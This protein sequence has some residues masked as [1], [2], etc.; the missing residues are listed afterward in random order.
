MNVDPSKS[1][2]ASLMERPNT[3][4]RARMPRPSELSAAQYMPQ[5]RTV[6]NGFTAREVE[7][8]TGL[9]V[10]MVDYLSREGYL[11]PT[12]GLERVRGRVR[13]YS[14]RDLMVARIVQR[15]RERGIELRRLKQ[16]IQR[17]SEDR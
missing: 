8:I 4:S 2:N 3:T 17:L 16:S 12:Y 1:A 10:P 5:P 14:Y 11:R 15:L 6:L 13:F 7:R 9:S